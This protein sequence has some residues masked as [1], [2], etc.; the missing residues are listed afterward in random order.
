MPTYF[1]SQY[2]Q[3][4]ISDSLQTVR[5]RI[6]LG[7][8]FVTI[9]P[10]LASYSKVIWFLSVSLT[11]FKFSKTRTWIKRSLQLSDEHSKQLPSANKYVI[12]LT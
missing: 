5:G 10:E 6:W 1:I 9:L 4:A 7:E 3:R 2:T 11:F 8:L 12:L